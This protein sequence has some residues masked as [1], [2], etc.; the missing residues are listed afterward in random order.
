VF[1]FSGHAALAGL[2]LVP[3]GTAGPTPQ[4]S[5][6]PI[7]N[8]VGGVNVSIPSPSPDRFALLVDR[9]VT[10]NNVDLRTKFQIT[11]GVIT[12]AVGI[13]FGYA[14]PTHYYVVRYSQKD[15]SLSLIKINGS[16]HTL[17]QQT[18]RILQ[19]APV[20]PVATPAAAT[21]PAP[22][23]AGN[24]LSGSHTLR[25]QVNNGVIRAWIDHAKRINTI[26]KTYNG[27]RVG[28]WSQGDTSATFATWIVDQYDNEPGAPIVTG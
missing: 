1:T 4:W 10:A 20:T 9:T 12:P 27:G 6:A 24:P 2:A 22:T 17:L 11:K 16:S 8:G 21:P 13:V 23:D 5:P 18:P 26:D 25:V 15:D 28:L 14:D 19:S 3:S 7:S